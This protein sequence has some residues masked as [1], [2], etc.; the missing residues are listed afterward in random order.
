MA[1]VAARQLSRLRSAA[2]ARAPSAVPLG[3]R[4]RLDRCPARRHRACRR[5]IGLGSTAPAPRK[6]S[7]TIR[8]RPSR[9]RGPPTRRADARAGQRDQLRLQQRA[10]VGGRQRADLLQ[11][12]HLEADKV[13]YD[14]KTKRLQAEGNVRLTEADGKITYAD[15]IDLSDDFRDGFVNSLRLDTADETRMAAARADAPAATTPCSRA[16]STPP[17]SP[18]RTIRRSRRCGRSRPRAS[19]TTRP[20]R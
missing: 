2:H 7:P 6:A 10:R 12:H 19:S 8:A 15:I 13:I 20:R 18:A 16:A 3:R 4:Q 11:R 14:Q 9:R 1:V 17:A 5:V